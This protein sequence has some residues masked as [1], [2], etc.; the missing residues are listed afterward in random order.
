MTTRRIAVLS[1]VGDD[2]LLV[3]SFP[4]NPWAWIV[5][6]QGSIDASNVKLL[7]GTLDRIFD[8]CVSRI[9]IDLGDVPFMS[10][11]A[12]CCLLNAH[13]RARRYGGIVVFVRASSTI[14]DVFS[15]LGFPAGL[16]FAE[17]FIEARTRLSRKS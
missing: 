17:D 7:E 11:A 4:V 5:R 14:R 10:S 1:E 2:T 6:L 12:Y 9:A 8:R 15:I 13:D 16:S 3:Q